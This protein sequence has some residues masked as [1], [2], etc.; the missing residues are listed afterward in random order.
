MNSFGA[1]IIGVVAST[2]V[3]LSWNKLGRTTLFRKVDDTLGVFH[4]HGVAGLAG[5]LLVGVVADP[6][7]IVYP[8][9][10]NNVADVAFSGWLYGHHPKQLLW[11]AGAAATVIAWDAFVT[12][13]ILKIAS[14]FMS[15]RMPDQVL[16]TGDVAAHEE[17][18]YPDETLVSAGMGT[19]PAALAPPKPAPDKP[20]G[21]APRSQ[22]TT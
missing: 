15:L 18:A 3:W 12:F 6:H 22:A 2:L 1:M 10:G 17:E 7:I 11:Q 21:A 4:T 5:G 20:S 14:L 9:N 16:E 8:G 19:L 13:V